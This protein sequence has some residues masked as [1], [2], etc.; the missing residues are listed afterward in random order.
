EHLREPE[1]VVTKA[2]RWLKD[3]GRFICSV[4]NVR[5]W[6]IAYELALKGAWDYGD[7]GIL[8]KTHLRFFT[9][10]SCLRMLSTA[11][12]VVTSSQM[13]IY[14]RRYR[15]LNR[16]TLTALED[17]CGTQLLLVAPKA[18]DRSAS[19]R[20]SGAVPERQHVPPVILQLDPLLR[21]VLDTVPAVGPGARRVQTR[22]GIARHRDAGSLER[23]RVYQGG[24]SAP[25]QRRD[26]DHRPDPRPLEELAHV[27]RGI[28]GNGLDLTDGDD[29]DRRESGDF[30][31]QLARARRDVVRLRGAGCL[32]HRDQHPR[33]PTHLPQSGRAFEQQVLGLEI[34]DEDRVAR[35]CA[36]GAHE[37]AAERRGP[38]AARQPQGDG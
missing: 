13:L 8:D 18:K 4:P 12:F 6:R 31:H 9:R 3:E 27:T 35:R 2:H 14:G 16:L 28:Q 11:G 21:H 37:A 26:H 34:L 17:L 15:L 5:Y 23:R 7:A 25:E 30:R 38:P 36:A 33:G 20:F 10:A 19:P 24:P 22:S 29:L 1:A 32:R